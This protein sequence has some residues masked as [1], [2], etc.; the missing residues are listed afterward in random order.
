MKLS[1]D[2]DQNIE[3][4][5]QIKIL[6]FLLFHNIVANVSLIKYL[7][8][9]IIKDKRKKKNLQKNFKKENSITVLMNGVNQNQNLRILSLF[10]CLQ[11][12]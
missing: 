5:L 6:E 12:H 10:K 11:D 7:L 8:L 4:L 9:K 3:K 1:I 2:N